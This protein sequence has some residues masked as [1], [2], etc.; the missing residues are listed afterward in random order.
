M[1]YRIGSQ[2]I[3][4]YEDFKRLIYPLGDEEASQL[5]RDSEAFHFAAW[6]CYVS[7]GIVGLDVA[8]AFKPDSILG[9]EWFDRIATGAAAGEV[10]WDLGSLLDSAAG[11]REYNA[12]Q[13]YN[14]LI[15]K[16][17]QAFLDLEPRLYLAQSGLILGVGRNF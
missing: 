12:V 13:R 6:L 8:L 3:S 16:K 14:R 10:F 1:E 11:A 17:D 15:G 9:V 4:R 2:R 7:G 5:I